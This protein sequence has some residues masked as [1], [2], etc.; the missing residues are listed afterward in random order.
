[1][2]KDKPGDTAVHTEVNHL[3]KGLDLWISIKV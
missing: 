3:I 1:M 2:M